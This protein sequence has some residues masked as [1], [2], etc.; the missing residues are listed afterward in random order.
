MLAAAF[1]ERAMMVSDGLI[2]GALGKILESAA[3][4]FL[5]P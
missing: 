4:I 1:L 2:P 5:Y 3:K